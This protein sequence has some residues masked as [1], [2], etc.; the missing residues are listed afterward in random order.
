[1]ERAAGGPPQVGTGA[2]G[3]AVASSRAGDSS[4]QSPEGVG[5][6]R[7]GPD[8]PAVSRISRWCRKMD[9]LNSKSSRKATCEE[10][11][12]LL[13]LGCLGT[14]GLDMASLPLPAPALVSPGWGGEWVA[15]AWGVW[16]TRCQSDVS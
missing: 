4:E 6:S 11:V 3:R 8:L 9:L 10:E 13:E 5:R 14:A 12:Q 7:R 16:R 2:Q 1:M 15:V